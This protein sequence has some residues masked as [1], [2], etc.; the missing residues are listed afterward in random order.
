LLADDDPLALHLLGRTLASDYEVILARDGEEAWASLDAPSG[1]RLAVLDWQ[2]PRISGT[3]ICKRLRSR[4]AVYYVLLLTATRKTAV[5]VVVGFDAGAD[6]Y[7]T[8]PFDPDELR[9][10][11]AVGCRVLELQRRLAERIAELE[12]A[13]AR[14]RRLEGLL[15]I[16]AWCKR[17][18]NAQNAWEPL[19]IYLSEHSEATFTHGMCPECRAKADA[20]ETTGALA[21]P[22][23]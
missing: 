6:D 17:I 10:R 9:A 12:E 2:M 7:L 13:L 4:P 18:R 21:L 23:R 11:V 1:P 5:D 15:P 16:C 20:I 19:E 22:A 14:I 3:E 8:K